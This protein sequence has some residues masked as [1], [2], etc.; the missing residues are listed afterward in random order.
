[1][2]DESV[3]GQANSFSLF[4]GKIDKAYDDADSAA[5]AV[6]RCTQDYITID[7]KG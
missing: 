2:C 3:A 5:D 1:M 4:D 6:S 7:G